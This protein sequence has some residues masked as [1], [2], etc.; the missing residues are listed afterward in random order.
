MQNI[1][2]KVISIS[3]NAS[4]MIL[5]VLFL[6]VIF[7]KSPKWIM[8]F[9]WIL[10]GIR[11]ICPYNIE[12]AISLIPFEIEV[13]NS[14]S[15]KNSIENQKNAAYIQIERNLFINDTEKLAQHIFHSK[16][17]DGA[18]ESNALENNINVLSN[19]IGKQIVVDSSKFYFFMMVWICGMFV[20]FV[21]FVL[22][23]IYMYK[24]TETAIRLKE[25]IWESEFVVS[26]YIFGV[27]CPKIF[28]PY[29]LNE[30]QLVY[31]LAHECAH[32][33]RKDHILKIMAYFVLAVYWF[34]P[35][36]WISYILLGRD[37]EYACDEKA[38]LNMDKQERKNYLL[39]LLNCSVVKRRASV[40]P[41]AFGKIGIKERVIRMKRWKKP[42]IALFVVTLLV[43]IIVS[44]CFFTVP[45]IQR[46]AEAENQT[47]TNTD[48]ATLEV[49]PAL[50]NLNENTG[51]DGTVLY[52]VDTS[53]II[54]GGN[55]GLFVYDK[56]SDRIVQSLDLEYIACNQT[57]GDNYCEI[58]VDKDGLMI[59]LNP[60]RQKKLYIFDLLSNT[61]EI[62]NYPKSDI[63][64]DSSLEL[65]HV[66]NTKQVSY[67]DG[68]EEKI[69]ILNEND[70][71]IGNCSYAEYSQ[72]E[73]KNKK[74]LTYYHF[75]EQ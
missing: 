7:W 11:L 55:Y 42:S 22:T 23:Y 30:E 2:L 48:F 51:A 45:K 32:L 10:V 49:K 13:P 66:E 15:E 16:Y 57:Q 64:R 56:N 25:N 31:I 38:V 39:T 14:Y 74:K 6:R 69:C 4:W 41:L 27:F 59:Y 40:Y 33:K 43:G 63:W 3:M 9:L 35:L 70:F 60:V 17:A 62:R 72:R 19:S 21:Y 36:V 73:S 34:H 75:F 46:V 24:Q 50:V 18:G 68:G 8:C 26:P 44:V 54:F 71:T 67:H 65:F 20:M 28:I 47:E 58:A 52:Y 1:F 61:L 53:K 29:G 5:A 12:S 37:I